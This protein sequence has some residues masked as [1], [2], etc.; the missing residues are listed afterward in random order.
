MPGP[1]LSTCTPWATVDDL[2]APCLTSYDDFPADLLDRTFQI[3]SDLLFELSGRRF[4]GICTTTV[5]P[6][7]QR[8]YRDGPRNL[9][10][11]V[12]HFSCGCSTPR[13]CGCPR[14][15]EITLG[16]EPIDSI[17]EVKIDGEV[18]G[19]EFYRVDD[20]KYLVRLPD[21]GETFTAWPCCQNILLS[22]TEPDT[23]SVSFTYGQ[24]PPL[25]GVHAA[26]ILACELALACN[27]V[28]GAECR[29]PKRVQSLTRQG[30]S[31]VFIDPMEFLA[32]GRLGIY[33]VDSFLGVYNPNN[34]R[35]SARVV[36]P[37]FPER[38]RRTDTASSSS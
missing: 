37:D 36:S 32:G 25:A 29:L 30:I 11:N 4:P 22:D 31:M 3:A 9:N 23:F 5:R 14:P 28:S 21:V 13:S 33:E 2:C 15:S 34:L 19:P 35:R 1:S 17:L 26:S 6:C 10:A 16:V 7:S 18:L 12:L 24:D 8:V 38:V 27:P 20:Y